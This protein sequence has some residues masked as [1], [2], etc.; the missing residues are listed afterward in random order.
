MR[1]SSIASWF[2]ILAALSL[3]GPRIARAHNPVPTERD[4]VA[5][6]PVAQTPPNDVRRPEKTSLAD[7]TVLAAFSFDTAGAP[8][9]QGW[10]TY[11]RT[12]QMDTFFH[13]AGAAELNG[14]NGGTLVP[15]EG[16]QS[17]WCG[18]APS[19]QPPV[20]SYATLPGYGNLWR[21][22][23]ELLPIAVAGDVTVSY[24][25]RWDT[26][27]GYDDVV[28]E[29][30]SQCAG[31][32]GWSRAPVNGGAGRYDGKGDLL[33]SFVIADSCL[34]DTLRLRFSFM[35]DGAG[36]DEDGQ[37]PTDGEV[38]VD[39]IVISDTTGIVDFQD[40]ES[41][42]PGARH[43]SDGRW[44]AT[45][46]EAFGNFA[47]LHAGSTVVQEDTV[48]IDAT[49][50]WGFFD[51]PTSDP[52][53]Y[54][55]CGPVFPQQGIVPYGRDPDSSHFQC[56][57]INNEIRSPQIPVSRLGDDMLLSFRVYRD[58][59][60]DGNLFYVWHVRSWVGGCPGPWMDD[61]LLYYGGQKSWL[62][63]EFSIRQYIDPAASHIQVAIGVVDYCSRWCL[64]GCGDAESCHRHT[65]LI[66]DVVISL[67]DTTATAAGRS[68]G[69]DFLTANYPN[70]FNP[71]TTIEFG[72]TSA[73]RVSLRVYDVGGRLVRT[74]YDG[75][76]APGVYT[77][78]WSGT[79]DAGGAASSGVYFC[80]LIA[81]GF[82]ETRKMVL[83]K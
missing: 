42:P 44:Q 8:D 63:A 79:T 53:G 41:E 30:E 13:I 46:G 1:N 16:A 26:E 80:R 18:L 36:S 45:V 29:Y 59:P 47:A 2:V 62:D 71:V 56:I 73:G 31:W 54:Y 51:D 11:D 52:W 22:R 61:G 23:F 9:P 69:T 67:V 68:P 76:R 55:R 21:Q 74:L 17:L 12:A 81:P 38:L 75:P 35:S 37:Y 64:F 7:T 50:L 10:T 58:M 82:T 3:A 70:P 78:R 77:V 43:T 66:D 14:G 34:T 15:L 28:V 48:Y 60:S 57:E 83:L 6:D 72:T 32:T 19:G 20:C 5:R 4:R 27:A 33:E 65:P 25:I 39:S 49:N 40:F 24:R